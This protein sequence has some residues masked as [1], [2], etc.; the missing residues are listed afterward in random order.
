MEASKRTRL[1]LVDQ[2]TDARFELR[3]L[4][5]KAGI[6]IAGESGL[7]TE[8]VSTAAELQPDVILCGVGK[9]PERAMQTM[10][11]LLDVLPDTPI[12][13][14]A[15]GQ[16]VEGVRRAMLA[17]ARDFITMP[18]DAAR[19]LE[20]LRAVLEAQERRRERVSGETKARTRGFVVSVF[21][22]K[23]GVGKTTVSTNVGVA[24][25]L[26]QGQS[27]VLLDADDSFGDVAG[28]LDMPSKPGLIEFLQNIDKMDREEVADHVLKHSSGLNVLPA[29]PEP[30]KWREVRPDD[31]R[32]TIDV[33]A[34]RFDVLMVD[35]G[36]ML[37][38][39]TLAVLHE[40]D[41]VLWITSSDYSSINNSVLGLDAMGQLAFPRERIRVILNEVVPPTGTR[42][43]RIAAALG[44]DFWWRIPY[45]PQFR[46]S[47]QQGVP[48]VLGG[49]KSE[50]A[51]SIRELAATLMGD[52]PAEEDKKP[53][54]LRRL[55]TRR[56]GSDEAPG[57]AQARSGVEPATGGK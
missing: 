32:R 33:L 18:V 2:S 55:F 19:L 21:A 54:P 5:Q 50:G 7:G 28:M 47:S 3:R 35:T 15:W 49:R 29:P 43:D 56:G 16:D 45:D 34:R 38:D 42:E 24:L 14:Y 40:S 53:S 13:A 20:S 6:D 27:V 37:T 51:Q 1:L 8:A 39:N 41:L 12:I 17:G 31:L 9:P 23:G 57:P 10:E 25:G 44:Q 4:A 11:S 46:I 30:L 22:A 52:T 36:A 26:R 48:V